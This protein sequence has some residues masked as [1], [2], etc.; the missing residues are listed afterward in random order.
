MSRGWEELSETPHSG[1]I[2]S[3]QALQMKTGWLLFKLRTQCGRWSRWLLGCRALPFLLSVAMSLYSPGSDWFLSISSLWCHGTWALEGNFNIFFAP[4]KSS[5]GFIPTSSFE[6]T[7]ALCTECSSWRS[8]QVLFLPC[9][10]HPQPSSW[11]TPPD[12]VHTHSHLLD[13]I[14][15]HFWP[16]SLPRASVLSF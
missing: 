14:T 5:C 15:F 3:P 6:N 1:V 8:V 10:L 16:L 13:V 4:Q 12:P 11:S 9:S 7:V 2:R